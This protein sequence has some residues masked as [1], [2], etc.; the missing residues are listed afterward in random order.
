MTGLTSVDPIPAR[1]RGVVLHRAGDLRVE[2]LPLPTPDPHEALLRVI[3]CGICGTD[4][5]EYVHGPLSVPGGREGSSAARAHVIGHEVVGIVERPAADGSS[6]P[7]GTVVIGDVVIGCNDCWW[8]DRHQPGQCPALRVRGQHIDGGMADYMPVDGRTCV[9]VPEGVPVDAAVLAEPLAVAVRAVRKA[10]PLLGASV[11][12][13]GGGTVGQ[14]VAQV[15]WASG[16]RTV[17]LSDP[18]H[19][20]RLLARELSATIA[21]APDELPGTVAGL[22]PPGIDVVVECTAK[23]GLLGEAVELV[24]PGGLVV[25]VGLRPGDEPIPLGDLVLNEK[26]IAGTAA[27]VWD[28]DVATGVA[29]IASGA[30]DVLPLITRT[31]PLEAVPESIASLVRTPDENVKVVARIGAAT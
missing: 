15:A 25:A 12:V 24:R 14:L 28:D 19:H 5:E 11:A 29:L 3:A 27:H 30:V 26:R 13:I 10:G 22:P 6:P 4:A 23:A 9:V 17:L 21:V 2:D 7:R 20:R 16:A 8:C 31:V 1:M 18:L